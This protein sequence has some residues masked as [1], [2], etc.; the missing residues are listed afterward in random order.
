[1][2]FIFGAGFSPQLFSTHRCRRREAV[3]SRIGSLETPGVAPT[4]PGSRRQTIPERSGVGAGRRFADL[5]RGAIGTSKRQEEESTDLE[6]TVNISDSVAVSRKQRS[7][8]NQAHGPP[9]MIDQFV[10]RCGIV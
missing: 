1:M 10:L 6:A 7:Y 4:A 9:S 8:R 2:P 3:A 5:R